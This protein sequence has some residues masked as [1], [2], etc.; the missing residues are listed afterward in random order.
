[1]NLVLLDGGVALCIPAP[2][3]DSEDTN[4]DAA[5]VGAETTKPAL[6]AGFAGFPR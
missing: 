1:M 5:E 6:K 3:R 2:G 4:G